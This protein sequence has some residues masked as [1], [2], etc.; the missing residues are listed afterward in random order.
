MLKRAM[1]TKTALKQRLFTPQDW[2]K[3]G[4][5]QWP[6]LPML[7]GLL[8]GTSYIP[9]QP[10]ALFF[11]LVPL[12][13][14][15]ARAPSA[16]AAFWGGW[17]AQF[18]LNLI[19]FHWVAH[20]A[21]E[22]GHLPRPLALITL[23]LFCATAHLYYPLAGWAAWRLSR[24][25]KREPAALGR[26]P[27]RGAG[28]ALAPGWSLAARIGLGAALLLFFESILPAI[29]P[30]HLGYAWIWAGWPGAQ[31]AD[32]IGFEG[33]NV[34][35]VAV[36]ACL[37]WAWLARRQ[38]RRAAFAAGLAAALALAP[39]VLGLGRKA[40]WDQTDAELN[41]LAVQGN[42]GN[43]EKIFAQKGSGYQGDIVARYAALTREGL[44]RFPEADAVLWPETAFPDNLDPEFLTRPYPQALRA[45]A[46]EAN[47]PIFTGAYSE[48]PRKKL[49]YNGFFSLG[50]NGDPASQGYRKSIL[51]AFGE[52]VPGSQFFPW[53]FD[54]VPAISSF[55]RGD[56]PVALNV[57]IPP[58]PGSP[59]QKRR[60][61]KIGPQICYEGLY[62]DFTAG[63]A[64]AGAEIV[65]NVTNDSWF[66]DDFE[67][68]QHLYM[69][70]A[71]ALEFRRPLVRATNTGITTAILANGEILEQ[72]PQNQE[73]FGLFPVRYK[74]SPPATIYQKIE[75]V[76]PWALAFLTALLVGCAH[77]ANRRP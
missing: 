55:G 71:R 75:G 52:Y 1:R 13:I 31:T 62:P 23:I 24:L 37:A 7:S 43:F 40:A 41:V 18:T 67:P 35:T 58:R 53:I 15:W 42:I 29:F 46:R 72:S 76:W 11:C 17:M 9:F 69:T 50:A 4:T 25:G 45:F 44:A 8:I 33:L 60:A 32:V 61:V 21:Y 12:F 38:A 10:W 77:V 59:M 51:L 22:F 66:G 68:R 39:N 48:D 2:L 49:Y 3:G 54:L 56:G 14:A 73:W 27:S 5:S 65:L 47:R 34:V 70:L 74:R 19:G 30:W 64:R 6:L 28:A 36:N 26:K 16:R 57:A 20:T 63:L